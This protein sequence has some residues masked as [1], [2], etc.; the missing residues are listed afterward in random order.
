M[1]TPPEED[2]LN[3]KFEFSL[4]EP[5]LFT[6]HKLGGFYP[7]FLNE[8]PDRLKEFRA[9]LQ[10][11]ARG[12]QTYMKLLREDLDGK[13]GP[14]LRNDETMKKVRNLRITIFLYFIIMSE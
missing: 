13:R 14:E 8:Q 2:E 6:F 9:R 12:T 10:Y 7:E 5:L 4:I 3:P 11:L 1:P